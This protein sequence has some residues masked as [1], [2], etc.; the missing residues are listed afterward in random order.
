M[1]SKISWRKDTFL[2]LYLS[3]YNGKMSFHELL[4]YIY[5]SYGVGA[6]FMT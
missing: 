3:T 4:K 5:D 6:A 2:Q 1:V